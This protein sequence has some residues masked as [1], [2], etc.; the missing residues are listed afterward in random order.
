MYLVLHG[1]RVIQVYLVH[2]VPLPSLVLLSLLWVL[3]VQA[4]L[5]VLL[6][7]VVL[8]PLVVQADQV[9]RVLLVDQAL[10]GDQHVLVGP[11]VQLIQE[12]RVIPA[13]L[14]HLFQKPVQGVQVIRV[15]HDLL[16]VLLVQQDLAVHVVLVVLVV[17]V[18]L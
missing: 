2:H 7:Q 6:D 12:H 10:H 11:E 9:V 18:H 17:Q 3:V 15:R 8:F 4:L 14:F 16:L 1:N 13:L 5:E